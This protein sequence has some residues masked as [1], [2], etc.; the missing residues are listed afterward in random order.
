MATKTRA[1][2]CSEWSEIKGGAVG[3]DARYGWLAA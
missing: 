3:H 1:V 2:V